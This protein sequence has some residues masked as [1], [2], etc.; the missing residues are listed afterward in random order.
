MGKKFAYRAV[1]WDAETAEKANVVANKAGGTW[2]FDILAN[3]F[4]LTDLL[5]WGFETW[6]F[7]LEDEKLPDSF[8]EY[9]ESVADEVEFHECPDCGHKWPK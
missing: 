2:D 1:R 8:P 4:E 7:G 3:E 9:D 5:E 6:E